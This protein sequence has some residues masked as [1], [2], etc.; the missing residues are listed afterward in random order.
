M[1]FRLKQIDLIT[2][3]LGFGRTVLPFKYLFKKQIYY[4]YQNQND[5]NPF[6]QITVSILHDIL[7]QFQVLLYNFHSLL[8]ISKSFL[9]IEGA[10]QPDVN[11][12]QVLILPGF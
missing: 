11:F 8:N 7:E 2:K 12:I 5:N 4:L 10:F 6:E 3:S 1:K 9:E